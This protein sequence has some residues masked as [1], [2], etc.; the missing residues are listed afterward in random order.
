MNEH[1]IPPIDLV[2]VNLYPFEQTVG[3][4]G[5]TTDEAI[6]QIDIGGPS[7]IRSAAKNAEWVTV[8]TA[9][10]QYDRFIGELREHAGATT[11]RT[12]PMARRR[13]LRPHQRLRPRHL[14]LPRQLHRARLPLHPHPRLR[15]RD[16]LR[17]GENPHQAAALYKRPRLQRAHRRQRPAALRKAPRLQQHPRRLRRAR[18]SSSP[19]QA[20]TRTDPAPRHQA[21][22]PLRPR[23]SRTPPPTPSASPSPAIPSPR[24][25][26]SSRSTP[27]IDTETAALSSPRPTASSR[28]SSPPS[29]T[30]TPRDPRRALEE[31]PPARRRRAPRR[32]PAQARVP[33]H[34]GR[35][36]RPGPRHRG[37]PR[38]R[39]GHHAAGPEPDPAL[40]RRRP[41]RR[42]RR[43]GLSSNAIAIGGPDASAP[44]GARSSAPAPDRWTASPRAA[45]PS[46]RRA[47]APG[48]RRRL[49][50]L[51]PLR[52]RAPDPHRRG[53]QAHRPPR[54]LQARPGDLRPLRQT[55][56][57]LPHHRHPPLP[58]LTTAENTP[59]SAKIPSN[60]RGDHHP[61]RAFF[62]GARP[63]CC[64]KRV[65]R[66]T[67]R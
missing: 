61:R 3:K 52:R 28:S 12:P 16:E 37:S 46:P 50:R 33:L 41:A 5:V 19:P 13:R 51:L 54:R 24:T 35:H 4:P 60:P 62:L 6:E 30:P 43:R 36:A 25:A 21:H 58:T 27:P 42:T 38:P 55:R 45:S 63:R 48:R 34:P 18:D 32:P 67:A 20:S 17:Y 64:Y 23:D 53:R 49:R 7:M 11:A 9:P 59:P 22:Q 65:C 39:A 40:P 8:L 14:R 66:E 10:R 47:T 15:P 31:C 26:A 1:A 44:G 29:S 2:C 57:D 56:R